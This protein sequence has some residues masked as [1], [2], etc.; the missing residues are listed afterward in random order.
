MLATATAEPFGLSVVEAMATATAVVATAAGA[1]RET[2][3]DDG[4][5][6]AP[7]DVDGC[8]AALR[9]LAD[10]D[11]ERRRLGAALQAR[12]AERFTLER[13][14]DGLLAIYE[15]LWRG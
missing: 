14:L 8:A 10:D 2:L 1:H 13:H 15:R 5:F 3:G 9:A 12:Y 7:G 6:F 11:D 4:R